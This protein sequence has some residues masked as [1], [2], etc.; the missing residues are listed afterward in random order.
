MY[1]LDKS[2]NIQME[3]T[4]MLVYDGDG[5][6]TYFTV[7]VGKVAAPLMGNNLQNTIKL[8]KSQ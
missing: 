7:S 1:Y 4:Q 6:A 3:N 5:D 8:H 2:M